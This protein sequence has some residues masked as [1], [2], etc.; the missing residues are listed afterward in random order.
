I[1]ITKKSKSPMLKR[2]GRDIIRANSSVRIPFAPFIRRRTL[3]ILAN[4]ITLKSVG[5]TK[6]SSMR[7]ERTIPEKGNVQ[8]ITAQELMLYYIIFQRG[9][10]LRENGVLSIPFKHSK[11]SILT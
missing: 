11:Y 6:Y 8:L 4:L 1:N 2:A 10:E 9:A 3:P 5:E 7:S